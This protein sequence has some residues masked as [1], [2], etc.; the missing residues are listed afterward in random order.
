MVST[1][2][3]R[4]VAGFLNPMK[5]NLNKLV[6]FSVC[7]AGI[8]S[9]LTARADISISYNNTVTAINGHGNP[10]GYW[11]TMLDT[12]LNL[13]LSLRAQT[14]QILLPSSPNDGAGTFLFPTGYSKPGSVKATWSY[15]FSVN[16]NPS[17][18]GANNLNAYDFYLTYDTPDAPGTF[19]T[20]VNLL[21]YYPDNAYG[22]NATANGAG[23][24]G[25]ADTS[26]SLI[27]ANNVAQNAENIGFDGLSPNLFG[28]YDYQLY[29]VAA[30]AGASAARLGEV[31]MTV[32]VT[33]EPATWVLTGLGLAAFLTRRGR[34][35]SPVARNARLE[36][37]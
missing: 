3:V 20:P 14:T 23:T 31:A 4:S 6:T 15:W 18:L 29:A 10:D 36:I 11:N 26:P 13:E 19:R 21:T 1:C 7:A 32:Y 17:G 24:I 35:K 22:N 34:Q 5:K 25:T 33:P 30:G 16:T 37:K 27:L 8:T 28:N 2:A 9:G 12:G